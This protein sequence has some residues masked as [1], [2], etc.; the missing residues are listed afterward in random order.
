MISPGPYWHAAHEYTELCKLKFRHIWHQVRKDHKG[1]C[2]SITVAMLLPFYSTRIA[3]PEVSIKDILIFHKQLV[4]K[5]EEL[6]DKVWIQ[7]IFFQTINLHTQNHFEVD[8][9]RDIRILFTLLYLLC[10]IS[11]K[12]CQYLQTRCPACSGISN[13]LFRNESQAAD[14]SSNI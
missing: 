7:L 5:A 9:W 12:P 11:I 6:L 10:A 14:R 13:L 2:I 8:N 1:L 4:S 3:Y